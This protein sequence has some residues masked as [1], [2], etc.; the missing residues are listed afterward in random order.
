MKN[1]GTVDKVVRI[2]LGLVLLS[3]IFWGPKTLWGL[4]GIIPLFTALVG[5]CPLYSLVGMRT[6]KPGSSDNA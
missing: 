5:W 1:V 6:N 2:I 3:L 4:L